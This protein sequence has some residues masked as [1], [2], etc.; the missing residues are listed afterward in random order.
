MMSSRCIAGSGRSRSIACYGAVLAVALH[1]ASYH[2]DYLSYVNFPRD[3]PYLS[4]SD[5]NVDWGQSLKQVRAWLDEHPPGTRP[6]TLGYF[7]NVD[8][9]ASA[10]D[11][12]LG[13]RVTLL[14]E[15]TPLP[16]RGLLIISPVLI[17]GPYEKQDRF[18]PLRNMAPADV[19]GSC[20]LV[21]DLDSMGD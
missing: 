7:G 10:V 20:M 1:S 3:K 12:Y 5:S 6:V 9:E 21:Y 2:P 18:G 13:D 8:P 17:A 15:G 11:Y 19:I 14:G 16:T 4:I